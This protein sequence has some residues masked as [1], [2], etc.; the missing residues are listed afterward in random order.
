MASQNLDYLQINVN[1]AFLNGEVDETIYMQQPEGFVDPTKQGWVYRLLKALYGLK[2]ASRAWRRLI[3]KLLVAFGFRACRQD[4]CLYILELSGGD[5]I[6]VLDYVDDL[7]MD[8]PYRPALLKI[9]SCIDSKVTI[10][11]EAD[12]TK[13]LEIVI[14]R[15]RALGIIKISNPIMIDQMLSKFGLSDAKTSSVPIDPQVDLN[16]THRDEGEFFAVP[17]VPY[18]EMVGSILHLCNTVRP[19]IAFACSLLSSF[20]KDPRSMTLE[21]CKICFAIPEE[22]KRSWDCIWIPIKWKRRI[23]AWIFRCRL[24]WRSPGPKV[25]KRLRLQIFPCCHLVAKQ[26]ADN[27]STILL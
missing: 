12:V 25:D 11:V 13:F 20:M 26:E 22:Y 1:A 10:R 24:C 2:Q 27:H 6:F 9:S 7:L 4:P 19:E 15:N 8:G 23:P 5:K 16:V 14:S 18:N 21:C 3:N 17:H